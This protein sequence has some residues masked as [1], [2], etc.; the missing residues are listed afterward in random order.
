MNS[1]YLEAIAVGIITAVVAGF[2]GV[3]AQSSA[4]VTAPPAL[5][6]PWAA[7]LPQPARRMR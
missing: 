7:H 4:G 2:A 3:G 5:S 1:R 6:V